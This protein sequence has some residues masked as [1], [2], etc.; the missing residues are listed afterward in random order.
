MAGSSVPSAR[1][2]QGMLSSCPESQ[3]ESRDRL[4]PLV[5]TGLARVSSCGCIT[6]ENRNLFSTLEPGVGS[7]VLVE[8]CS[9]RSF[10]AS[11][12]FWRVP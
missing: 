10:L 8:P 5:L 2:P 11:S 7:Q 6:N 4:V 9:C 12:S 1:Q 3:P